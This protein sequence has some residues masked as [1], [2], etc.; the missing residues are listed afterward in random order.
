M[1]KPIIAVVGNGMV[2]HYFIEQLQHNADFQLQVFCDEPR[3]AYDRVQLTRYFAE[4]D[5]SG[6]MLAQRAD[7][8]AAGIRSH[9]NTKVLRID[10]QAQQ[11]HCSDGNHYPY[12]HLVLATG[13]YPFIP[14]IPGN[15]QPH[16]HPYRTIEDLDA[17]NASAQCSQVGV[18]IGG[19]LLGLE[20][21]NALTTLGLTTHVVEFAPR[22]MAVQLDAD[23][24]ALLQQKIEQL[25]V[26]VHTNKA[27]QA[28]ET[29]PD[30]PHRYRLRFADGSELLTDMVVF[31]AGIRPQDELANEAGLTL[32]ERGGIVI[33]DHC[34][35][36]DERIY[37]IGECALWQG[38][39]F[40]LVAPGYQ[41]AKVVAAQLT[42]QKKA[43]Q[44]ADMSTKLKLLGVDVSSIGDAHGATEGSLSYCFHDHADGIYKKIVI[45]ADANRLLGAVLVGDNSDYSRLLQLCNNDMALPQPP[46][47]LLVAGAEQSDDNAGGGIAALPE[48]AQIC[49]CHDV[50]KADLLT[51]TEQLIRAGTCDLAHVK[52]ATKA[53]TGCGGCTQLVSQLVDEQ[54]AASGFEVNTDLCAHFAYSRT[55]L[56]DILRVKQLKTF[57]A[58]LAEYGH[59]DGCEICRPAVASMLASLWNDYILKNEHAALQDSNDRF[60][61]NLQKN[62]TYSVVPRIP[63][64][65]ITPEK[66]IVIGQ[67]AQ[68]FQLYTKITGGQRIDLFGAQL[69]ELPQIWEKLV[70]AGFETGHAYGKAM[71]TVKSCVGSSWCRFGV[72]DS[73]SMAIQIE[74]RYRGV[75]APHKIKLAVSGCV[76]E[77][78]EAQSKDFG[79]IATEAGWNLYV[80]GNG[81]MRPRHAD[82]FATDLDDRTLIQYIDRIMMFYV[83]SGDRLQRTSVWLEG[84]SGGLDYLKQVIIEDKLGICAELEQ[85]MA[86][87]VESYQCEWATTLQNPQRLKQFKHFINS[88]DCD[89]GVQFELQREQRQPLQRI[90]ITEI[91]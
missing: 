20:A 28:I 49:A 44:G 54:L 12:D 63:G 72:Q 45:N 3:L 10:R 25:G 1:S 86:Y 18:V 81:G 48:H 4:G 34:Q 2:G 52:S 67:V 76:R 32:G 82:L 88:D 16:I 77:C 47:S 26:H 36:N 8:D 91:S 46:Q 38:K 30:T 80:G 70:A 27:T 83:R 66:L 87:L 56:F 58:L 71:R 75:R 7:Y 43:F 85:Q 17:I 41:M 84:L 57:E 55:E 5:V 24:G 35:T 51:A 33:N 79:I 42:G 31:S 60:L 15:E 53:G 69:H 37:A 61:G 74:R 65:E 14:P 73:T 64:G 19:G 90:A 59:G 50:S 22:L 68:E 78:A 62:G 13:S 39:L 21:A 23:G 40:G 89:N 6:L 9:I 11:L 29:S